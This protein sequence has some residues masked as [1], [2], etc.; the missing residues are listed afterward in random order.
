MKISQDGIELV[1]PANGDFGQRSVRLAHQKIF[2]NGLVGILVEGG[3]IIP[4]QPRQLGG[5]IK[6]DEQQA[7]LKIFNHVAVRSVRAG[8]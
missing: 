1:K 3:A 4:Y 8:G 6:L 7:A 2:A 5:C